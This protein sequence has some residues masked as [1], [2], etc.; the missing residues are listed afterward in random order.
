MHSPW[1]RA[2]RRS[3]AVDIDG[4]IVG[5]GHPIVVQSMTN[6]DTAD[7]DA[8]AIQVAGWRMPARSWSGS[9]S[10]PRPPPPPC[11]RSCARFGASARP[12]RSSA[13]STTTA[14]SCCAKFPETARALAK[15]RINPGNV[16]SGR[17]HDDHFTDIVRIAD[18]Q[19]QA[20]PDRRQLGLAGPGG[21]GRM[22]DA[23]ARLPEP[24]D[25]RAS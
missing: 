3:T 21:P 17:H 24:R 13:T 12:S 23:N 9:R 25:A 1:F 10:T 6:T 2:R 16:G 7:A 15:Y 22:M 14:I 19:R 4:V 20:G 18:R 11:R 5:A 8:T